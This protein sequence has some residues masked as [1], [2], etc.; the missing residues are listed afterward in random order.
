MVTEKWQAE[1][2]DKNKAGK[3]KEI[4][5]SNEDILLYF[6]YLGKPECETAANKIWRHK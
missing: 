5:L 1:M 4:I 6:K 3:K 2:T